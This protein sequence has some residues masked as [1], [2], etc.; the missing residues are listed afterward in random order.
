MKNAMMSVA[1]AAAR[2]DDG[3]VLVIAGSEAA[4]AQLP[5]GNWIGGTSVYF[6]TDTGG[7]MD[8]ENVFV[9]EIEAA[10]DA[11]PVFYPAKDLPSLTMG[12]YD[13]G[14]SVILIPAFS[15]AHEAF[16]IHGAEY[17]GLFDQPLMGWITG[18]PLDETGRTTPKVFDGARGEMHADGAMLLHVALPETKMADLDI[19]NLFEPDTGADEITF[20][21]SG[22]AARR[23]LI[24]GKERDFAAYLA[25]TAI[26]TRCPLVADY[27][28]AMVNVSVQS[29]DAKDGVTFYAPVIEGQVYHI[30]KAP[31]DYAS[32]FAVRA[33]GH[34]AQELSC[35]CI[36]NY[37]YGELDTKTTGGFT[38]PAT[39][40][41][42]AYVLLNQTL[43]RL[44]LRAVEAS[45]VA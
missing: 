6:V 21:H 16:A 2:I 29:V 23:A 5:R 4:L 31:G 18:V 41:E 32:D 26:D 30:A 17:P 39:F 35:N 28:G 42:I 33:Q 44:D 20:A 22:F 24:N 13:N 43:V 14:L 27:A 9:T 40:G 19:I 15:A 1:E 8:T 25:E 38:G 10:T 37:L 36:L 34:G 12:R 45:A 7:R 3:A 11:R